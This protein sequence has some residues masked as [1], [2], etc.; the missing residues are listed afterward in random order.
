MLGVLVLVLAVIAL[1]AIRWQVRDRIIR[2]VNEKYGPIPLWLVFALIAAVVVSKA[3]RLDSSTTGLLT[4][5]SLI[6]FL[7]CVLYLVWPRTRN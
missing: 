2:P 4:L 7:A 3:S 6:S 1:V 5:I